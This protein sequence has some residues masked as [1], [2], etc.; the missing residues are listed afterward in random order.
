MKRPIS[1]PSNSDPALGLRIQKVVKESGEN[2]AVFGERFG[3]TQATVS[4]WCRGWVP[5]REYWEPLSRLAGQSV[6]EFILGQPAAAPVKSDNGPSVAE[7]VT[8]F[9]AL[10]PA[11]LTHQG[12]EAQRAAD[13]TRILLESAQ[14]EP[15]EAARGDRLATARILAEIALRQLDGR[16][17]Q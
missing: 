14:S 13:L 8:I 6:S 12:V 4:R 9:R 15:L 17:P 16:K 7:V 10:V 5:D 11:I 1:R 3:V 2:Q